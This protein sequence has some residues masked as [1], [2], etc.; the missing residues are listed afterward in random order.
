MSDSSN[1]D[2]FLQA[3]SDPICRQ[4]VLKCM[5]VFRSPDVGAAEYSARLREEMEL[6]LKESDAAVE[7]INR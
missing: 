7:P 2:D 5:A 4:L 6:L 1:L 3:Q